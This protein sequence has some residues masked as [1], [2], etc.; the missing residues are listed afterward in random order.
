MRAWDARLG[1]AIDRI[2]CTMR[3]AVAAPG[4]VKLAG[5]FKLSVCNDENCQIETPRLELAVPVG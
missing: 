4:T 2:G 1:C 5:T 3:P